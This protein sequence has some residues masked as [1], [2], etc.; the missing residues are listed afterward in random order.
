MKPIAIIVVLLVASL[1]YADNKAPAP[2]APAK[3]V[4]QIKADNIKRAAPIPR[5]AV[6]PPAPASAAP[7]AHP[8]PAPPAPA[9]KPNPTQ[10]VDLLTAARADRDLARYQQIK[11]AAETAA[12]PYLRELQVICKDSQISLDDLLN[13]RVRIDPD[14]GI[15]HRPPP[16]AR[17]VANPKENSK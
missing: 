1:G 3:T 15:I 5:G 12:Q 17:V 14:T 16:P 11:H 7:A 4:D 2:A 9:P 8:A 6:P 10:Q 13:E